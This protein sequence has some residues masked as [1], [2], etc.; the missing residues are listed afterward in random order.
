MHRNPRVVFS[1]TVL[2]SESPKHRNKTTNSHAFFTW[3]SYHKIPR[4]SLFQLPC[5][6]LH[7]RAIRQSL[8]I[9]LCIYRLATRNEYNACSV[10]LQTFTIHRFCS[11]KLNFQISHIP[12]YKLS[13]QKPGIASRKQ[14]DRKRCVWMHD[15]C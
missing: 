14:L 1:R 10:M 7:V 8:V 15:P 6:Y 11:E 12:S 5:N 9:F 3:P 13:N 4:N 2:N